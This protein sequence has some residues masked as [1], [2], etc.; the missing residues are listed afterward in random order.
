VLVCEASG[1]SA[2][3][4]VTA[5]VNLQLIESWSVD[6]I[7]DSRHATTKKCPSQTAGW[8]RSKRGAQHNCLSFDR[9]HLMF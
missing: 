2:N 5:A 1:E 4:H 9:C 7:C 6:F 8:M 3:P